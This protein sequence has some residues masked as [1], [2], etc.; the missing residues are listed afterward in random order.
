MLQLEILQTTCLSSQREELN[1][2]QRVS[3]LVPASSPVLP[4]LVSWLPQV[5]G[6]LWSYKALA[7][8][9]MLKELVP[10]GLCG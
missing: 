10:Q 5:G 1:K 8:P 9:A 6:S 4:T 2:K 7:G 3:N